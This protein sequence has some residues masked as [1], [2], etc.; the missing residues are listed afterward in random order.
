MQIGTF[1][2]TKTG[3]NGTLRTLTVNA[4]VAFVTAPASGNKNAPTY[5]LLVDGI[6]IGAAWKSENS[7]KDHQSVRIED[8]SFAGGVIF[9]GFARTED[10]SYALFW[11]PP[12]HKTNGNKS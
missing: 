6:K 9:P 11:Y 8:P 4:E 10:G 3:F 1:T 7:G 2:A 12:K 5:E